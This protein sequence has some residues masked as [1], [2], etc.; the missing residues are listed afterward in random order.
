MKIRAFSIFF[1]AF[2][3]CSGA[4]YAFQNKMASGEHCGTIGVQAYLV[5][6]DTGKAYNVTIR[7]GFQ[8]GLQRGSSD[9]VVAIPAGGRQLIGCTFDQSTATQYSYAVVGESPQ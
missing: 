6:S 2:V 5:N 7:V 8:R 1:V 4:L 9:R 3:L